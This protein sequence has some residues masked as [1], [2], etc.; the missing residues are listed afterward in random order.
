[1]TRVLALLCM[2]LAVGGCGEPPRPVVYGDVYLK[3]PSGEAVRQAGHEVRLLRAEVKAEIDSLCAQYAAYCEG[4][5]SRFL[6]AIDSTGESHLARHRELLVKHVDAAARWAEHKRRLGIRSEAGLED[7]L[8]Q[9]LA[10][11][12]GLKGATDMYVWL[13]YNYRPD[14]DASS[15]RQA[16]TWIEFQESLGLDSPDQLARLSEMVD[17]LEPIITARDFAYNARKN[18]NL[19]ALHLCAVG[20]D[21]VTALVKSF[22][23]DYQSRS[24]RLAGD[25][26]SA[27]SAATV[28]SIRTSAEGHFRLRPPTD[29]E[30]FVFALSGGRS[31]MQPAGLVGADS[32]EVDLGPHNLVASPTAI[33]D[34]FGDISTPPESALAKYKVGSVRTDPIKA[35][36]AGRR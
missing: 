21:Q 8:E 24:L 13:E 20:L 12:A 29:G 32:L 9:T 2:V 27:I 25:V 26:L 36:D 16:R 14:P 23:A 3:A 22:G 18:Y 34:R 7:L 31:W 17:R 15:I 1:M 11:L 33:V 28:D 19:A 35:I 30:Y 5:R 6:A 4:L 10:E